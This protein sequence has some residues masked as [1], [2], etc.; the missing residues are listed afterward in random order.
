MSEPL[1]EAF[2]PCSEE[3]NTFYSFSWMSKM[4]KLTT[5]TTG[6]IFD[7]SAG[8]RTIVSHYLAER[9]KKTVLRS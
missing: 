9:E 3:H 7:H 5:E 8:N 6:I 1:K 2:Q 4:R